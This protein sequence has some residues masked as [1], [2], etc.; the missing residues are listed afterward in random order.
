MNAIL[1][2]S[3]MSFAVGGAV[4][5]SLA[6][7]RRFANVWINRKVIHL[8]AVPAALAYMYLY[9]EPYVFSAFSLC[10]AAAFLYFQASPRRMKWFQMRRNL[11]EVFFCLSFAVISVLMWDA[12]RP[13]AGTI[14]L[15][16]A[17]GDS[18]TGVVR[19]RFVVE[20]EKHWSGSV[21]MFVVCAAVALAFL[22]PWGVLLALAATLAEYQSWVDD[23]LAIPLVAGLLGVLIL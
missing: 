1:S 12:H 3:L 21:A 6:L 10:L 13:L 11:G 20:R 4:L 2:D 15:F 19:S 5:L 9:R 17:V 18:V 7:T 22:G 14:M 23:N 16:M 8:S